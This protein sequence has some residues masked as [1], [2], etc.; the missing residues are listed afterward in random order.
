[1]IEEILRML[2]Q[3]NSYTGVMTL[4]ALLINTIALIVVICQTH[5]TKKSAILT[6]KN[7]DDAK[8]QRQLEVL[9][10]LSWVIQVRVDLESWEKDL[11][12]RINALQQSINR[13]DS[14]MLKKGSDTKIKSPK[15]LALHKYSYSNMP[16]WLRE[17][18][19]SGAQYYYDAIAPL[20]AVYKNG[21]PD[22]NYIQSWINERGK[23][24]LNAISKLLEYVEDMVPNVILNTPASISN[25]SFLSD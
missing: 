22:Y 19:V 15:D 11:Q 17:L 18:R 21:N 20:D 10:K 23:D 3:M 24:S 9:P 4:V 14:Q 1:M 2:N 16:S 5:F 25:E 8:I 7:I 6:K 12:K 13:E